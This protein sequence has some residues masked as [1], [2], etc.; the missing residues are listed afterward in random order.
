MQNMTADQAVSLRDR[1]IAMW[2]GNDGEP[3]EA[4]IRS[5]WT[6]R[7]GHTAPRL[8]VRGIDELEA[9]VARSI[10]HWIVEERCRFRPH[11]EPAFHHNLIRFVWEMVDANGNVESVGTEILALA[12]DGKIAEAY[13]FVER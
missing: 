2:N 6:E 1:Y 3:V 5:L 12:D 13:Q 8:A 7:G 9:R 11:G 4:M 10:Q